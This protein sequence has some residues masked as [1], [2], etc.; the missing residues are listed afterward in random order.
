M[1]T[2]GIFILLCNDNVVVLID[3]HMGEVNWQCEQVDL[4]IWKSDLS[5]C[6]GSMIPGGVKPD[7]A[8]LYIYIHLPLHYM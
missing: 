4:K 1:F 7:C 8:V 6:H 3:S 2:V 5:S